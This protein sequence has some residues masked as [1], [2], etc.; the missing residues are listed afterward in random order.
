MKILLPLICVLSIFSCQSEDKPNSTSSIDKGSLIDTLNPKAK[1][2]DDSIYALRSIL[3]GLTNLH[4]DTLKQ[5]EIRIWV[6]ALSVSDS[7]N[8]IIFKRDGEQWSGVWHSFRFDI[9]PSG[10]TYVM[11]HQ[12]A[13]NSPRSGWG[14]FISKVESAGIYSL[15]DRGR[16]KN[17]NLCTGGSSIEVEIINDGQYNEYVYPCWDQIKDQRQV[18]KIRNVLRLTEKEFG[19]KTSLF[20]PESSPSQVISA[21]KIEYSDVEIKEIKK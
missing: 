6:G 13:Q 15:N 7:G 1:A 19:F 20:M 16:S 18:D 17:S 12:T 11:T 8:V 4:E 2:F 21:P 9:T 14:S 10:K 5:P 3:L